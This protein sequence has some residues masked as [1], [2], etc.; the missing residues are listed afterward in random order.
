MAAEVPEISDPYAIKQIALNPYDDDYNG[1]STGTYY[2]NL[3]Y[4]EW[5]DEEE[6]IRLVDMREYICWIFDIAQVLITKL[7]KCY[8]TEKEEIYYKTLF[9][10]YK[11]ILH[12]K[13]S[14]IRMYDIIIRKNKVYKYCGED[15][16]H[17]ICIKHS[18]FAEYENFFCADNFTKRVTDRY[19]SFV[20]NINLLEK[21]VRYHRRIPKRSR[22]KIDISELECSADLKKLLNTIKKYSDHGFKY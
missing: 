11:L 14:C 3:K 5:T 9:T 7:D 2:N 10:S 18:S 15:F 19:T 16:I 8:D 22:I 17:R 6:Y 4:Y 12:A 21:L 13:K 1:R 20:K